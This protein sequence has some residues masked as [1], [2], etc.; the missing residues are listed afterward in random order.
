M[1]CFGTREESQVPPPVPA[2]PARPGCEA[3]WLPCCGCEAGWLPCCGCV[4][5][6]GC[7]P[8]LPPCPS[9]L[10]P[11]ALSLFPASPAAAGLPGCPCGGGAAVT[12]AGPL[13]PA[14]SAGAAPAASWVVSSGSSWLWLASRF[15]LSW[16]SCSPPSFFAPASPA[17]AAGPAMRG[18]AGSGAGAPAV[19]PAAPP[20]AGPQ[21]SCCDCSAGPA[22]RAGNPWKSPPPGAGAAPAC[23]CTPSSRAAVALGGCSVQSGEGGWEPP[24]PC[25]CCCRRHCC[26]GGSCSCCAGQAG[27]VGQGGGGLPGAG[28]SGLGAW[29]GEGGEGREGMGRGPSERPPQ[30]A[31]AA[32]VA[33]GEWRGAPASASCRGSEPSVLLLGAASPLRGR[34]PGARAGVRIVG[35]LATAGKCAMVHAHTEAHQPCSNMRRACLGRALLGRPNLVSPECGPQ[36]QL[37]LL[38]LLQPRVLGLARLHQRGGGRL[39]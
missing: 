7:V 20:P 3:G 27:M 22:A 18:A 5:V 6:A 23:C 13:G 14:G 9:P 1:A 35:Q 16:S 11:G 15:S 31:A 38:L 28:P 36:S 37:G 2:P 8:P 24:P 25:A 10:P 26:C 17:G 32:V 30:G 12:S 33:C 21:A 4:W 19:P 29:G 39:S 34:A